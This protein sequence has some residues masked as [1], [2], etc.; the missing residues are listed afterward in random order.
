M[1]NIL[2]ITIKNHISE[3]NTLNEV[4]TRLAAIDESIGKSVFK[5]NLALEEIVTNIISYGYPDK[6][7]GLINISFSKKNDKLTICIEDEAVAFNPLEQEPPDTN[8]P[9]EE[10]KI[11][12]LGIHFVMKLMDKVDYARINGKNILTLTKFLTN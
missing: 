10:Q 3:I 5:L 8:L 2:S 4:L 12:G 11:G 6:V 1:E 9:A 7:D